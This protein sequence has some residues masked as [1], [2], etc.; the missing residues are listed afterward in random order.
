MFDCPFS[1]WKLQNRVH[2]SNWNFSDIP[3]GIY[4]VFIKE[5]FFSQPKK[6]T[7]FQKN[8]S[9]ERLVAIELQKA[10]NGDETKAVMKFTLEKIE[11]TFNTI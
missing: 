1:E 8:N 4:V 11:P 10:E 6:L 2:F 9:R 3:L 7:W 5:F